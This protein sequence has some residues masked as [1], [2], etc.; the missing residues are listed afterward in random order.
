MSDVDIE[1]LHAWTFD[2]EFMH[3]G[4]TGVDGLSEVMLT[5]FFMDGIYPCLPG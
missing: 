1:D 3:G 4:R 2:E 5:L